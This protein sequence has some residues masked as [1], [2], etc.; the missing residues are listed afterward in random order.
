[1]QERSLWIGDIEPWMDETTVKSYFAQL[2]TTIRSVKL[3]RNRQTGVPAGYGFVEFK[4]AVEAD[5][6]FRHLN[7][8]LIP[9]YSPKV[10]KLNR[11][12]HGAGTIKMAPTQSQS[13]PSSPRG[14]LDQKEGF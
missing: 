9:G 14:G 6:V 10:F 11:A 2:Q 1:M 7:G 13:F 12:M 8:K 5:E 4:D 3:I